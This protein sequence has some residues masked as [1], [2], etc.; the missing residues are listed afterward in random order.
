VREREHAA[1][2]AQGTGGARIDDFAIDA[3]PMEE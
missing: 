3:R 1:V 2:I